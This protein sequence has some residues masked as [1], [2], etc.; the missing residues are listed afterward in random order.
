MS[1]WLP[2]YRVVID[3]LELEDL[4]DVSALTYDPDRKSLFT[5]TNRDMQLV[6]LSLDGRI[7]R[8][9]ALRGFVDPEAVEYIGP[10]VYVI[11]DEREQ[12]LVRVQID[13]QGTIYMVSEPNLFYVFRRGGEAAAEG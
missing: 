3:G 10:G 6:E 7:L 12:R 4:E 8:R 13:E 5:V 2:D 11:S 9:I 1:L